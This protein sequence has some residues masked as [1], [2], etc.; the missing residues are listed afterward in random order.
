M[1]RSAIFLVLVCAAMPNGLLRAAASVAPSNFVNELFKEASNQVGIATK[2]IANKT[3]RINKICLIYG[4]VIAQVVQKAMLENANKDELINALHTQML[5]HFNVQANAT[6]ASPTQQDDGEKV[7]GESFD[8]Y[9]GIPGGYALAF[10][11]ILT[12]IKTIYGSKDSF[13]TFIRAVIFQA[14]Q[15]YI[16]ILLN[17]QAAINKAFDGKPLNDAINAVL[18]QE[19]KGKT[20]V[21]SRMIVNLL[22]DKLIEKTGAAFSQTTSNDKGKALTQQT[23]DA[24][25]AA[26]ATTID[27]MIPVIENIAQSQGAK[28]QLFI[29]L[30]AARR[31]LLQAV[32]PAPIP[33][34]QAQDWQPPKSCKWYD[35]SCSIP[36][37]KVGE[38]LKGVFQDKVGSGLKTAFVDNVYEKGLKPIGE[39]IEKLGDT[40]KGAADKVKNMAR[41]IHSAILGIAD[42][43]SSTPDVIRQGAAPLI[44]TDQRPII[45]PTHTDCVLSSDSKMIVCTTI[46]FQD[47]EKAVEAL[48]KNDITPADN[49][50]RSIQTT[51]AP[52]HTCKKNTDFSQLPI[53]YQCTT[54]EKRPVTKPAQNGSPAQACIDGKCVEAQVTSL[55]RSLT[56]AAQDVALQIDQIRTSI[57][58]IKKQKQDIINLKLDKKGLQ[59][60]KTV[61]ALLLG[62]GQT[63]QGALDDVIEALKDLVGESCECSQG[64]LCDIRKGFLNAANKAQDD[65][66]NI[67]D[68]I[69]DL[70]HII[71]NPS[72]KDAGTTEA[73][74][75]RLRDL[76]RPFDI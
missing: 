1:K 54:V 14:T 29:Q 23:I 24:F 32:T 60:L 38:G 12:K 41:T 28:D 33:L 18:T 70:D 9:A 64:A 22:F 35:L 13:D 49:T 39:G 61:N 45:T 63:K 71:N 40:L 53:T 17:E 4:T 3:D 56:S 30:A 11:G 37:N 27:T 8:Q 74:P 52:I 59:E 58:A 50:S 55:S 76:A 57:E 51:C 72:I 66:K 25:S 75:S 44:G 68:A 67:V 16:R 46:T 26:K 19:L 21:E 69:Q 15:D 48:K 65:Q 10:A 2:Q 7:V 62:G 31:V 5:P 43:L 6:S 20:A 34:P 47:D 42:T 73:L 36:W